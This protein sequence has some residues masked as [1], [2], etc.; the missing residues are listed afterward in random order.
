MVI[1][2]LYDQYSKCGDKTKNNK[3]N[4]VT[5]NQKKRKERKK[6]RK[7]EKTNKHGIKQFRIAQG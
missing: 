7:K 5:Y 4:E 1:I 3:T 2:L 6:E